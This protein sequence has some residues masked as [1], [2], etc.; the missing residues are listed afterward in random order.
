MNRG[1]LKELRV[2]RRAFATLATVLLLLPL[3]FALLP[4]P[5]I[6]SADYIAELTGS[7]I[8]SSYADPVGDHSGKQDKEWPCQN[9]LPG[10]MASA[11]G[12]VA[13]PVVLALLV[14]QTSRG[15]ALQADE[16]RLVSQAGQTNN[17]ARAPPLSL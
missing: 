3:L 6:A 12:A 5:S 13:E 11:L 2:T 16:P 14:P 9:C 4:R 7:S 17:P 10:S 1:L 15:Q 8:C